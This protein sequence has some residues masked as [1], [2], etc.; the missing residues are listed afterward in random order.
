MKINRS[1]SCQEEQT[2]INFEDELETEEKTKSELHHLH[3]VPADVKSENKS[4][5]AGKRRNPDENIFQTESYH[6]PSQFNLPG[7]FRQKNLETLHSGSRVSLV[8]RV[9]GLSVLSLVSTYKSS[10]NSFLIISSSLC[11]AIVFIVFVL[12]MI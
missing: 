3:S 8:S 12:L 4:R 1:V 9:T 6:W 7:R 11:A 2:I 10:R 5:K